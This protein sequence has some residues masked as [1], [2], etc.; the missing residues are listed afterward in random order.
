MS[1]G[2]AD[3]GSRRAIRWTSLVETVLFIAAVLL[4]NHFLHPEDPGYLSIALHPF[5]PIV[6][7][8]A[9]RYGFRESLAAA[10]VAAA[11]YIYF[12]VTP[13]AGTFH[14][15]A[16]SLFSDF[17]TPILFLI[18][19][20]IISGFT[21]Q[22]LERT[23]VLRRHLVEAS[24][25]IEEL[26]ES[27]RAASEALRQLESRIAS[28]L[29]NIL[30]LFAEL[31][32]TKQMTSA[33]IKTHLLDVLERHIHAERAVVYDLERGRLIARCS[34]GGAPA[35]GKAVDVDG[36][37]VLAESLRT[38]TVAHLGQ[39]GLD[40]DLEQGA[41]GALLAGTLR[42]E[43]GQVFGL[44]SV[45]ALPFVDYNPHTFKLFGTIL[46]WWSRILDERVRL[47]E[48]RSRSVYDEQLGLY[49]FPY[50]TS[51]LS[52]EFE[53]ARRFS[54]PLSMA[55][56][57]ARDWGEVPADRTHELRRTLARIVTEGVT[58]LEMVAAYRTEDTLAVAFPISMAADA[59]KRVAQ[60]AEQIDSFSF[61]PY[62]ESSRPLSIAWCTTE[63]EIGME[64][65]EELATRAE[66]SLEDSARAK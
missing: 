57:R 34:I 26:E 37:V 66:A 61:E 51:R 3:T 17:R 44:V 56:I 7:L 33:Q 15:S 23:L 22:L 1:D 64:D 54:L 25:R 49:N 50:F 52:Q 16:L 6:I 19:G 53:R 9:L 11:V 24:G 18:V 36:D 45:E 29:T 55:L 46:E 43:E 38:S 63:Y 20:G 58:G 42:T 32:R 40:L 30:D 41:G 2:T 60:I 48:L 13:A 39:F 31:A 27:N 4:A 62:G 28:E 35:D 65:F 47:E 8:I 59:D 5:W 21:Q 12:A 10:A 14:F